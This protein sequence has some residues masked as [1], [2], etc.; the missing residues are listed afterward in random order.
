MAHYT[1]GRKQ[2]VSDADDVLLISRMQRHIQANYPA[3]GNGATTVLFDVGRS[4]RA[5]P[6]PGRWA[7][8][9]TT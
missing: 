9:L 8:R 4:C 2:V 3:S 7:Q 6:E 1:L 5:V